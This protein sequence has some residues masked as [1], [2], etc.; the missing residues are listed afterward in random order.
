MQEQRLLQQKVLEIFLNL[1]ELDFPELY[2]L[3]YNKPPPLVER[4]NRFEVNERIDANGLINV[5]LDKRE[6]TSIAKKINKLKIEAVAICFLHSYKNSIHEKEAKK[7][8]GELLSPD[9][10]LC[11]SYEI[12]PEIREYERTST[13]VVNAYLGPV[14]KSYLGNFSK[15]DS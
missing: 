10:F 9:I 6:L 13:T 5:N 2:N 8:L 4:K 15:R 11:T 12:L 1:E 14:I 7:I 3:Q